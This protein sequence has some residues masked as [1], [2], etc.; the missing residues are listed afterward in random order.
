MMTVLFGLFV[1]PD[2]LSVN[3][4]SENVDHLNRN[5]FSDKKEEKIL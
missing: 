5:I 2:F 1:L 3:I 4:F